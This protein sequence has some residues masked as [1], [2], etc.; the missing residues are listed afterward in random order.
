MLLTDEPD[1]GRLRRLVSRAF[2]PRRI[3]ELEPLVEESS[4]R[5]LEPL[6]GRGLIDI[7]AEYNTR[8]VALN[9]R[10]LTADIDV[11]GHTI[12]AGSAVSLMLQA[13]IVTRAATTDPVNCYS[14][15]RTRA[16]CRSVMAST[17]VSVPTWPASTYGSG[18]GR[19]STTSVRT[20]STHP[21]SPGVA[22]LPFEGPSP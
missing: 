4:R 6:T 12:P 1:H 13:A 2:T 20:R 21:R 11:G 14:I 16:R 7:T 5:L 3:A 10:F 8:P 22:H 15:A 19:S 9:Q 18:C 17:T